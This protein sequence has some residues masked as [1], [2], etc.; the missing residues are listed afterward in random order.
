MSVAARPSMQEPDAP[1]PPVKPPA[2]LDG[3]K[4]F[5]ERGCSQCHEIRGVGGRRGPDLSGVGRRLKK[6]AIRNQILKGGDAMPEFA[7]ALQP[8]EIDALSVYLVR[9]RDKTPAV[10]HPAA[11]PAKPAAPAKPVAADAPE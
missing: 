4:S 11:V 3:A 1:A 10:P 2:I 5:Q 6:D 7:D 9:L 8:E